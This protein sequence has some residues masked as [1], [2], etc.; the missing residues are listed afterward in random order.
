[1]PTS[2]YHQRN[3]KMDHPKARVTKVGC[4][5]RWTGRNLRKLKQPSEEKKQK[6][7]HRGLEDGQRAHKCLMKRM[8]VNS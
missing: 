4:S 7:V 1:M 6:L 2:T 5:K 8:T 3:V